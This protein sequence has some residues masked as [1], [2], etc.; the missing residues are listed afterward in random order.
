MMIVSWII[1]T[2]GIIG[3]T[4]S[5]NKYMLLVSVLITGFGIVPC[6]SLNLIIIN[7]QFDN[8]FR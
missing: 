5:L 3:I 1:A 7:E 6:N 2:I 4:F 8:N